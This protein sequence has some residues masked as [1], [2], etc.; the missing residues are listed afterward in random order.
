MMMICPKAGECR[1]TF[2]KGCDHKTKHY[3]FPACKE[4]IGC[5]P[6][7]IP[8]RKNRKEKEMRKPDKVVEEY[9]VN[10]NGKIVEG[11]NIVYLNKKFKHV[12]GHGL[13]DYS[14]E[15]WKLIKKI[16][17]TIEEIEKC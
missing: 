13:N 14:H 10:Y 11:I 9:N 5:Y 8:Y 7:C 4:R 12:E 17:E 15:D 6:H 3:E 16:A 1:E 2:K